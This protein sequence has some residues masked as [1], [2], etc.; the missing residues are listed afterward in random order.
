MFRRDTR[1]RLGGFPVAGRIAVDAFL[2]DE[3]SYVVSLGVEPDAYDIAVAMLD[4]VRSRDATVRGGK[5]ELIWTDASMDVDLGH[6]R[7]MPTE[8]VIEIVG[9]TT[10]FLGFSRYPPLVYGGVLL[11]RNENGPRRWMQSVP[12][13]ELTEDS[14]DAIR[15]ATNEI[16]NRL[17]NPKL[18]ERSRQEQAA[19]EALRSAEV[20]SVS[21]FRGPPVWTR[22]TRRWLIGAISCVTIGFGLLAIHIH[23]GA[24]WHPAFMIPLIGA[25]AVVPITLG[26]WITEWRRRPIIA[27]WYKSGGHLCP[28]CAYDVSRL[29][30]A[31]SCPECGHAYDIER[32]TALWREIGLRRP[33]DIT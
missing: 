9:V 23:G 30:P 20:L 21:V 15:A 26:L 10:Y 19:R 13:V 4:A 17:S 12:G 28:A 32:D 33:H 8:F 1:P 16:L 18:C 29:A 27:A 3:R 5:S 2:A 24:A 7:F 11:D 14:A 6:R 25:C 22:I 31:G